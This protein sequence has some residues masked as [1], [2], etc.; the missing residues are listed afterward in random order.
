MKDI[1][2]ISTSYNGHMIALGEFEKRVQ[3]FDLLN[4]QVISEFDTVKWKIL[5]YF[6]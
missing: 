2:H 5:N 1:R 3:I 4:K 6:R